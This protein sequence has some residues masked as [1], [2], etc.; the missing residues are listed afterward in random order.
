VSRPFQATDCSK[1][2]YSMLPVTKCSDIMRHLL[3]A[4]VGGPLAKALTANVKSV[5]ADDTVTVR[6]NTAA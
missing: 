3:K 6:A 5:F 4:D 2:Y 1:E